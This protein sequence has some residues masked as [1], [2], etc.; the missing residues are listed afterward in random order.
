M[1][2]QMLAGNRFFQKLST[3]ELVGLSATGLILTILIADAIFLGRGAAFLLWHIP[4]V[5][6]ATVAVGAM[7]ALVRREKLFTF[8]QA[9]GIVVIGIAVTSVVTIPLI[10]WMYSISF[11]R[12]LM[13]ASSVIPVYYGVYILP[14]MSMFLLGAA[15]TSRQLFVSSLLLIVILLALVIQIPSSWYQFQTLVFFCVNLLLG[16]PLTVLG[17]QY[18]SR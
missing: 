14:V 11:D 7:F 17:H 8:K 5:I 6:F 12:V 1:N 13:M 18:S 3:A 15:Q 10:G 4:N 16:F 9:F 2:S